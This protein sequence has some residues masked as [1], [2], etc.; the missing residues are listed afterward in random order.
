MFNKDSV[1]FYFILVLLLYMVFLSIYSALSHMSITKNKFSTKLFLNFIYVYTIFTVIYLLLML[2]IFYISKDIV[3]AAWCVILFTILYLYILLIF[4]LVTKD[5]NLSQIFS[6]GFKSMMKLHH[7]LPPIALALVMFL[8]LIS[9]VMLIFSSI[10]LIV[11]I[12]F[13]LIIIYLSNWMKKYLH[14]IIHS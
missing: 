6:H 14:Q 8:I 12:L 1:F 9:I 10:P 11:F 7:T 4:Y 3:L 5:G 2:A 13:L